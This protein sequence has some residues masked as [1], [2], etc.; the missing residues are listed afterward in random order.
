ML[1]G[2]RSEKEGIMFIRSKQ[3]VLHIKIKKQIKI[4]KTG[5]KVVRS[6]LFKEV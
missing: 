2:F 5:A 1:S 6:R 4:I 3:K